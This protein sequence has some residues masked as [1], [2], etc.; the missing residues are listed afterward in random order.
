TDLLR[1]LV[2]I[3]SK[4]GN[5][6]LN[7]G[8]TA[9]G[10]IPMPSVERLRAM[11]VWLAVN[12]EAVY[13]TRP[14]P[15]QGLEWCRTTVRPGKVYLHVFQWPEGGRLALPAAIGTVRRAYLLA[16][17]ARAA[18][19]VHSSDDGLHIQGPAVAPDAANTV[20][21]LEG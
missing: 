18:L 9:E 19:P 11:G 13:A 15:V 5:Y 6:L 20:V 21:V 2:D 4:G 3:T 17:K 16:D 10:V 8:P 14:G 7:V 12:G 1:K